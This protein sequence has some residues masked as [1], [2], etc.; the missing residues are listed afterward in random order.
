MKVGS[1]G[2]VGL[3]REKSKKLF[4]PMLLTHSH[5]ELFEKVS[6]AFFYTFGNNFEIKHKFTKCLKESCCLAS[7]QHFSFK[8]FQENAFIS[9]IFPKSK[10]LFWLL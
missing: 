2:K 3:S 5:S 1:G 9:K 8:L 7:D 6:S 4:G 10:C